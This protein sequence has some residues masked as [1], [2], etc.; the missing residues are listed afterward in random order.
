MRSNKHKKK[1][2]KGIQ[3]TKSSTDSPGPRSSSFRDRFGGEG[4][5]FELKMKVMEG[6]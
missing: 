6:K 1:Q 2:G 5:K 4:G 3:Q